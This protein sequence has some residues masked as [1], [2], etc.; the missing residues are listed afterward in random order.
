MNF[1]R[2]QVWHTKEKGVQCQIN[3][4]LSKWFKNSRYSAKT[5]V[6]VLERHK[7]DEQRLPKVQ[8]GIISFQKGNTYILIAFSS[9]CRK[10]DIVL[11]QCNWIEYLLLKSV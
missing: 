5:N 8:I 9:K 7:I 1:L 2:G 4:P 10:Y 3:F 6:N 11:V